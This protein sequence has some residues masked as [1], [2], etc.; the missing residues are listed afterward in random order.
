MEVKHTPGPWH[1]SLSA[2]DGKGAHKHQISSSNKTIAY[3]WCPM[4]RNDEYL[5]S[6][7]EHD[8]NA[9]LIQVAPDLLEALE[10]CELWFSAHKD[11]A[12]M[13]DVCRAAIAKARGQS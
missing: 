11:G 4:G 12:V 5:F 10:R 9:R 7:L 1:I 8:A 6:K 2:P 3:A 13:R